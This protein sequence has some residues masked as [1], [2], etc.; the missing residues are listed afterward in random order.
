M[1]CKF[2][3]SFVVCLQ[4]LPAFGI[5]KVRDYNKVEYHLLNSVNELAA[6]FLDMEL[7]VATNLFFGIYLPQCVDQ[8]HENPIFLGGQR[9]AGGDVLQVAS[10]PYS[11][12]LKLNPRG[13]D[14][15]VLNDNKCVEVRFYRAGRTMADPTDTTTNL[16]IKAFQAWSSQQVRISGVKFTNEF[17]FPVRMFWHEEASIPVDQGIIQPGETISIGTFIGHTFSCSAVAPNQYIPPEKFTFPE[18][19]VNNLNPAYLNILDYLVVDG[20]PYSF[21]PK[22]R[23]ETCELKPGLQLFLIFFN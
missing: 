16:E 10:L 11:E 23:I 9:H 20:S 1:L 12:F 13:T 19:N 5:M 6:K 22:N 17:P 18:Q 2:I 4:V 14:V 15:D 21:N 3:T 7:K 8:L